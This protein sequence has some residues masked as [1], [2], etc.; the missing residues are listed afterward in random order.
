M[1]FF[2]TCNQTTDQRWCMRMLISA[3]FAIVK[4]WKWLWCSLIG[5]WLNKLEYILTMEYYVVINYLYGKMSTINCNLKKGILE[6]SVT[7][8]YKAR[9]S[10]TIW[11]SSCTAKYLSNCP[12][13]TKVYSH[14]LCMWMFIAAFFI[15]TQNWKKK[16]F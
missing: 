2:S 1:D 13:D 16:F 10:L 6:D 11:L 5:G 8:S 12:I 9:H 7:V 14:K 4:N 3:L 15:I